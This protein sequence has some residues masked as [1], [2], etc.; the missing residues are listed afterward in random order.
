MAARLRVLVV[1]ASIAGPATAYWLARAGAEVT[2]IE[3]FPGI[4]KGGQAVDIRGC[5]LTV[6]RRMPGMEDL[7]RAKPTGEEGL[8]FVRNDGRPYGIIR[9]TGNPDQ[10]A[11]LSELE[12]FRGDLSTIL[13]D[14]TN[15][16]ESIRYKFNEQVLSIKQHATAGLLEVAFASGRQ[17]APFDLVVAADGATSRTRAIGLECG[18]RDHI[19]STDTWAAYFST[20]KNYTNGDKV[21][22]GYSAPGGRFMN[23]GYKPSGGSH[24]MM[25]GRGTASANAFR[26]AAEQG[27]TREFVAEQ[28][29]NAGW[30]SNDLVEELKTADDFY[31][32]EIVQVKVPTLHK[33]RFV[34]VGDAGYAVGPTGFGTSIA[35]AGAYVLAGEIKKHSGDV[36]AALEA[37]ERQMRPLIKDMQKIPPFVGSIAAPQSA[38]AIWV[39]NQLFAFVAWSG[40]AEFL[41][42]FLGGAFKNSKEFPLPEYEWD[43]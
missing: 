11:L 40:V 33:G 37:Y 10:Q 30:I 27:R 17:N 5:G 22:L 38:W 25:M 36:D 18:V 29:S 15:R 32:S 16:H 24:A 21:S 7:V 9:A 8:S 26:Q 39:R 35:L 6:M 43:E 28:Y 20:K 1:G 14:L 34:L 2:V 4:R 19:H 23:A 42:R 3:R 31:A 41:Q 12:I 13:H